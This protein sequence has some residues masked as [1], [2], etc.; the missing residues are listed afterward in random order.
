MNSKFLL[1]PTLKY[2]AACELKKKLTKFQKFNPL[3][4]RNKVKYMKKYY[5]KIW[6]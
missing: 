6:L 5:N 4:G 3:F 1:V 2:K